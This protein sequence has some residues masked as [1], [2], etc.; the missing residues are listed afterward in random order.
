MFGWFDASKAK[1]FGKSL[2][3]YFIDHVPSAERNDD[4]KFER[5]TKKILDSMARQAREFKQANPLNVYKRAQL[6]NNFKWAL[7]EAG[8]Q[9]SYVDKISLWL[10]KIL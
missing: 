8:F 5:K 7:K 6:V 1:D 3:A 4:K 2:A 9:E 10:V